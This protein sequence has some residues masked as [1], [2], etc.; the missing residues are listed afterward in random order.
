MSSSKTQDKPS[1]EGKRKRGKARVFIHVDEGEIDSNE[2][3][4]E[5]K[6]KAS[7]ATK[8]SKEKPSN[9]V[10]SGKKSKPFELDEALK[11]GKLK[12]NPP[13][14]LNEIMNE[15]VKNGNLKPPFEWYD[16]FDE[17]R[18]KDIRRRNCTVFECI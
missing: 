15:I 1:C 11:K 17:N 4:K 3:V 8:I 10:K 5:V 18:K 2:A 7:K 16:K 12:V 9:G 14:S 6:D 13:M